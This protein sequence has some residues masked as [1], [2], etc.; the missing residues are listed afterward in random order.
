[1]NRQPRAVRAGP[2]AEG[3]Q[4]ACPYCGARESRPV[5]DFGLSLMTSLRH[6]LACGADFEVIKWK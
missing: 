3:E 1:V 5:S 6:C 2:R 4:P